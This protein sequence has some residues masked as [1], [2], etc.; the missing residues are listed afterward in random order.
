MQALLIAGVTQFAESATNI[1]F[2]TTDE[3]LVE[4][5][6]LYSKGESSLRRQAFWL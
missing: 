2:V 1:E 6:I 5:L 3:V 4:V